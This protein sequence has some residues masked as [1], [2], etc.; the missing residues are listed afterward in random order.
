M[1][2]TERIAPMRSRLLKDAVRRLS[3]PLSRWEFSLHWMCPI[4]RGRRGHSGTVLKFLPLEPL[5]L[6]SQISCRGCCANWRQLG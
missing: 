6:A 4:E 1:S 2:G 5:A 3:N